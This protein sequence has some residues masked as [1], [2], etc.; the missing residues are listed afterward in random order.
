MNVEEVVKGYDV[1]RLK[2]VTIASHSSLQILRSAKKL[3][4]GTVAVAKPGVGWFYRRFNFI[5]RVIEV[6]FSEFERLADELTRDNAVLI[7]H[8]S[9]VEYVGWR[10]ALRM[11]IPTFGNRYLLEWEASQSKKMKLLEYAGIPIPKSFN[12]PSSVDRPVIVKLSGA[13]GGRGYFIAKDPREL[14]DKLSGVKDDDYIIQEYIVGVPAYYHYFASRVYGRV[15]LF[16]MDIRY[17]SNVDGRTFNLAEPTFVVVGNLP[18]VLRES[19]LPTVQRYGE[20]FSRAVS[21]LVPPGMIGPYSLESIIK[22]DLTIVVFEFS[23][24][25]VAGT[26]VYM[27]IG[28]QYSVLYFDRPMD[29]GERIAHELVTAAKSGRLHEV[30]T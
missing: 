27:G 23:G 1:D 20:E 16:G 26:N 21:E 7:P 10:R 13:K 11:P 17:E 12:D 24:R 2:V 15:E 19:L 25:I 22:D 3:G 9:Y 4:L 5:D 29:M 30:V 8:G 6:D 14:M 18:I 28:S